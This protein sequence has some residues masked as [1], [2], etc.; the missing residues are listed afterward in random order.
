M[1]SC[2]AL[3]VCFLTT[4]NVIVSRGEK[5]IQL[6]SIV[7]D[8]LGGSISRYCPSPPP[9]PESPT[10]S[11]VFRCSSPVHFLMVREFTADDIGCLAAGQAGHFQQL[12]NLLTAGLLPACGV[13]TQ[14]FFPDIQ[15]NHHAIIAHK[16]PIPPQIEQC[17]VG[18]PV[19]LTADLFKGCYR[20]LCRTSRQTSLLGTP[21]TVGGLSPLP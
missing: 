12:A 1:W 4:F 13:G 19:C 18:F 6:L 15:S 9:R 2:T 17:P 14:C 5:K 8:T 16:M 21:W 10:R 11:R 20:C 3:K 7:Q